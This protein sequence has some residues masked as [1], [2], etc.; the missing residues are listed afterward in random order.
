[1]CPESRTFACLR[2]HLVCFSFSSCRTSANFLSW[3][4]A[5]GARHAFQL[6]HISPV[7]KMLCFFPFLLVF[8]VVNHGMT[9]KSVNL[10][11]HAIFPSTYM[12]HVTLDAKGQAAKHIPVKSQMLFSVMVFRV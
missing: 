6:Q 5:S 11:S 9:Y 8:T 1:M 3:H 10:T 7:A 12:A 4:S 2:R